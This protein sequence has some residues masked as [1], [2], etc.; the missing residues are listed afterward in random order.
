MLVEGLLESYSHK[1]KLHRVYWEGWAL[2]FDF[3][4]LLCLPVLYTIAL[5]VIFQYQGAIP[6]PI[7]PGHLL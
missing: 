5:V 7:T 1:N 3:V 6:M 2:W 4:C